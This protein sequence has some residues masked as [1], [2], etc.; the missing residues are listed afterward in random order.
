MARGYKI[1]K[2][3]CVNNIIITTRVTVIC[4]KNTEENKNNEMKGIELAILVLGF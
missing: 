2:N 4:Q 3:S 1:I